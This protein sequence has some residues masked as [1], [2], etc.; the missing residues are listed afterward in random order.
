VEPSC[1]GSESDAEQSEKPSCDGSES[2]AEQ[3]EKHL[4]HALALD[5]DYYPAHF[6]LGVAC[7]MLGD[8]PGAAAHYARF[9]ATAP[10]DARNRPNA[11]YALASCE[12]AGWGGEEADLQRLRPMLEQAAASERELEPLWGP[13]SAPE[14]TMLGAMLGMLL[15][16][17]LG[18][19]PNCAG[20][21]AEVPSGRSGGRCRCRS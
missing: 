11:L 6:L 18:R 20:R 3:S 1:D 7:K 9:L 10:R 19:P 2:D 14:K 21:G 12:L 13:C 17:R 5:P 4:A 8:M 16:Q 15:A